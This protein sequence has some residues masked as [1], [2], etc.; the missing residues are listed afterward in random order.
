VKDDFHHAL[1]LTST[2][3]VC[4]VLCTT[5]L[6]SEP[7]DHV[8]II[9]VLKRS[10]AQPGNKCSGCNHT[11]A[12]KSDSRCQ[13]A[14]HSHASESCEDAGC[15]SEG[16]VC[17]ALESSGQGTLRIVR[18]HLQPPDVGGNLPGITP[19]GPKPRHSMNVTTM[20]NVT[21]HTVTRMSVSG[22]VSA[23]LALLHSVPD[24][25]HEAVQS[26]SQSHL[27]GLRQSPR[28]ASSG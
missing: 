2:L 6:V 20:V 25:S 13:K 28:P 14:H 12:E 22:F 24:V 18:C 19:D 21:D 3:H 27:H 17:P 7:E 8:S 10:L 16:P 11:R 15:W 23:K 26:R 5:K 9:V 4:R 1:L